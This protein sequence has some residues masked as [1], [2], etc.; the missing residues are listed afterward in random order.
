MA[1]M[2][3]SAFEYKSSG[4]YAELINH[5]LLFEAIADRAIIVNDF[6]TRDEVDNQALNDLLYTE[7][8]GD[9]LDTKPKCDCGALHGEHNRNMRCKICGTVVTT[10]TEMALESTLWMRVPEGV[11]SFISPQAW[12][13]LNAT[14]KHR[15][16]SL[17]HY[18]CDSGY[19]PASV[20]GKRALA[21]DDKI[22]ELNKLGWKRSLNFFIENFD[23]IIQTLFD[24]KFVK[25]VR[26]MEVVQ[27]F[28]TENKA[29]FFPKYL[30]IP[31]RAIFITEKTQLGQNALKYVDHVMFHGID[32][33]RT[34]MS[35]YSSISPITQRSKELRTVKVI[36]EFS[37]YYNAYIKENIASKPGMWRK[38][39]FGARLDRSGRAVITS[40]TTPHQYDEL[41]LPWGLSVMM[42]KTHITNKL[43]KRGF[44]PNECEEFIMKHT[45]MYHPLMDQIFN[46]LI[47]ES[48][49]GK[50][51]IIIQRNPTLERGSAQLMYVTQIKTNP[52]IY[53]ISISILAIKAMGAD[54]DGD[55]ENLAL[56]SDKVEHDMFSRLA[57][58]LGVMDASSPFKVS[59]NVG[60]PGPIISTI[61]NWM[62]E[63]D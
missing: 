6:D 16:I 2:E 22:A 46:E 1:E 40:L 27:Q 32:A 42:F 26:K 18:I 53:S 49:K 33:V 35:I 7:Y 48:P 17:I 43:L 60:I 10:V 28:I 44:T 14:F 38:Q 25:P 19:K 45:K 4:V 3:V 37:Q 54:F 31:N 29:V 47:S 57:P 11:H 63:L 13:I 20:A 24:M 5:D 36:N 56:A 62:H 41:H 58:H 59:N 8:E 51:G 55:E 12:S 39:V 52:K 34:L 9:M 50:L 21:T 61:G 30:P 15:G 23:M